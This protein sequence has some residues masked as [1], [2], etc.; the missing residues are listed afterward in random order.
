M[1]TIWRLRGLQFAQSF[2]IKRYT[3]NATVVIN[4]R[5]G[6]VTNNQY[7]GGKTWPNVALGMI[8][9][10]MKDAR[11][12]NKPERIAVGHLFSKKQKDKVTSKATTAIEKPMGKILI[13]L[14]NIIATNIVAN[15]IANFAT[16]Y[17]LLFTI[18]NLNF[19]PNG[20]KYL[21]RQR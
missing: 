13:A 11:P 4:R 17:A 7:C 8:N 6:M 20:C 9:S 2:C 21:F 3:A 10:L 14:S 19:A 12:K 15:I 18:K 5:G 16:L 1:L